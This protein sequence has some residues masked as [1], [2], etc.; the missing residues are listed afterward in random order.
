VLIHA[1][2]VKGKGYAPAESSA[3]KYHGVGKFDVAS[4][5]QAKA[6]SNAP[7]LYHPSSAQR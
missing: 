7:G 1:L 6:K 3:D 4:G 2:T 5:A